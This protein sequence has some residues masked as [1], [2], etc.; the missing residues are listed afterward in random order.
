MSAITW[1]A[2]RLRTKN[3]DAVVLPNNIL[4]KEAITNYSE[5]AAPTRLVVEVGA[6]YLTPP[7]DVKAAVREALADATLVLSTPPPDVIVAD[8]AASAI[9]YRILFW[10]GDYS[11]D[12]LARDQVR[13]AVYYAFRRRGIEIPYPAQVQYQ[14]GAEVVDLTSPED[15]ATHL[16]AVE[17]LKPL[18]DADR[19]DLAAVSH[20]RLYGAGQTIVR[21]GD[22]G[23]S[24]FVVATGRVRVTTGEGRTEVATI[25]AGGYFGEMSLL[26]GEPRTATVSAVTDCLLLEIGAEDLRRIALVHPAVV[27][28]IGEVVAARRLGLEQSRQVVGVAVDRE[29]APRS[30]LLRVRQFLRL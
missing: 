2:T 3:G 14:R 7:N 19:A 27:D 18:S 9:L 30:F 16:A 15:R 25:S 26:T 5:P 22:E 29:E 17:L 24:M 28:E 6:S 1:R 20:E 23:R 8:F 11:V 12:F 21:Q 13:T 10:V 4:S